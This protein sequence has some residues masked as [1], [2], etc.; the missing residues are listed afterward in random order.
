[1]GIDAA[2]IN[3]RLFN[4]KTRERLRADG[5]IAKNL[6]TTADGRVAFAILTLEDL[7]ELGLGAEDFECAIDIVRSL[8]GAE[9][10]VFIRQLDEGQYKASLRS[11][12]KNVA[13]IA[14]IF[15]G[16]GHIRAAG[17]TVAA[18]SA[19]AAKDAIIPLCEDLFK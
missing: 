9:I 1:M 5:F 2:D 3:H 19:D 10:A 4:T 18:H 11:T 13:E 12:G 15:G 7:K 14:A 17:C 16:G 8:K 6:S